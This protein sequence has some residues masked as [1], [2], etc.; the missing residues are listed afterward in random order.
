M[1]EDLPTLG[2]P[3][4]MMQYSGV[5]GSRR[6]STLS[7]PGYETTAQRKGTSTQRPAFPTKEQ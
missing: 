3:T 5:C 4:T 2:T 6:V 1:R 7:N